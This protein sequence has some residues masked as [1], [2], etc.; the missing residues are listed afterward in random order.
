MCIVEMLKFMN[1]K[2]KGGAYRFA[3]CSGKLSQ[4]YELDLFQ[5]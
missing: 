4:I 3:Y 1:W 5:P 2:T